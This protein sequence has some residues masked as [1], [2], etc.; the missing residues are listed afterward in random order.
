MT[1]GQLLEANYAFDH[2]L[3]L[4]EKQAKKDA[5]E[6]REEIRKMRNQHP[7]IRRRR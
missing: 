4:Q 2:L 6:A 5:E 1:Y 3:D 7:V